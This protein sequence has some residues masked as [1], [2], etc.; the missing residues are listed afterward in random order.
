LVTYTGIGKLHGIHVSD[1][2]RTVLRGESRTVD[3]T[4][5]R[6]REEAT[7]WLG[8]AGPQY[9]LHHTFAVGAFIQGKAWAACI[10][11]VLPE[12]PYAKAAPLDHFGTSALGV[13]TDPF[14][15][16]TGVRSAVATEDVERLRKVARVHAKRPDDLRGLLAAVNRRAARRS[17]SISPG[18]ITSYM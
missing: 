18:C 11:N 9:G 4:L 7:A 13:E 3:E 17:G 6:I 15:M 5:I 10:S 12:P 8:Q 1:W 16:I 14:I 2:L